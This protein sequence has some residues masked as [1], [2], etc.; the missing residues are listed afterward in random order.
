[1]RYLVFFVLL[2]IVVIWLIQKAYHDSEAE[3]A[4]DQTTDYLTGKT[5]INAMLRAR[6][7][8]RKIEIQEAVKYFEFTNGRSPNSLEE[9]QEQGFLTE[10]QKYIVHG[11]RKEKLTSG[12]TPDGRLF[13]EWVGLDRI[14]G[15]SD[16]WRVEF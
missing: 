15:T 11:R 5:Q 10:E 1:M 16:D 12:L 9:L 6:L 3:K 8:T 14:K 7:N 13:V 2:A 4:V